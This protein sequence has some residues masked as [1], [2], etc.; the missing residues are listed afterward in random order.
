[1]NIPG[2]SIRLISFNILYD[3][4]ADKPYS[5]QSRRENI[6]SL[7]RFHAPDVFCLQEPLQNQ[8]EDLAD[9]FND[10]SHITA[11]CSDGVSE[12]Q[13]MTTFFLKDKFEMLEHGKFGLSEKPEKL[14]FVGWDAKNPRLALWVKLFQ[15]STTNCFCV[16]N[17]H[18]DHIGENARQQSA[19]LIGRRAADIS[20]DLPILLCGDF[21]ANNDS[22]TYR[23]I[24]DSGFIDCAD[25]PTALN[26]NQPY[27][28]HRFYLEEEIDR[29]LEEYK[30]DPRV[31]K[32]IDHIFFKGA[33]RV[34]RHGILGD[35]YAGIYP[36]D[37]FPKICDLL[38]EAH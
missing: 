22:Q 16:I 23:N 34:L 24:K 1:M 27:S 10:Y 37:H 4:G 19:L 5:W 14:G 28:Y 18:L 35:N 7:L 25:I 32:V 2:D 36:S 31:L 30:D 12:G 21:N 11:G 17:T 9:Y 33:V 20:N 15:R 38:L 8:V 3:Y 26:Y 6:F 29:Y 13:H